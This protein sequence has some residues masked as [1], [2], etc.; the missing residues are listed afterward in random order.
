MSNS[1]NDADYVAEYAYLR[2]QIRTLEDRA[3]KVERAARTQ[4]AHKIITLM[5]ETGLSLA[6]FEKK[7]RT[8]QD[9]ATR[10]PWGSKSRGGK[11]VGSDS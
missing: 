9:K 3:Q 5:Q 2:D 6:D 11:P 1:P 7:P 8:P 10:A 4:A